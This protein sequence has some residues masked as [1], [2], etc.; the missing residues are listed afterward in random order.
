M[1][2]SRPMSDQESPKHPR[3]HHHHHEHEGV[4]HRVQLT[5]EEK[6]VLIQCRRGSIA[7][8]LPLG[9]LS[10]LGLRYFVQQGRVPASVQRWSFIYYVGVFGITFTMGVSSYRQ[11]CFQKIMNLENSHLAD[12]VLAHMKKEKIPIPEE[13]KRKGSKYPDTILD[14]KQFNIDSSIPREGQSTNKLVETSE[15]QPDA[16]SGSVTP[17]FSSSS[18]DQSPDSR[19]GQTFDEI[20]E[21]NRR[22]QM[23]QN[24]P[25]EL[26]R[27]RT[28]NDERNL[29][30]SSEQ[31]S[32]NRNVQEKPKSV[33]RNKYGDIIYED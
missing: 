2:D 22:Q 11:T 9:V 14:E 7:R 25:R 29:R 23:K 15:V 6:A 19:K 3:Y 21:R 20:R 13:W 26:D 17:S 30:E 10:V 12:Q 33:R 28:S 32:Q 16:F 1:A 27:D 4:K 18:V 8:G 31:Q 5:E 24:F